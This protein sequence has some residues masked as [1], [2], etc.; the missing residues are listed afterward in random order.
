M[1]DALALISLGIKKAIIIFLIGRLE[2][3]LEV[4]KIL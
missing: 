4:H 1:S 3:T 2:V